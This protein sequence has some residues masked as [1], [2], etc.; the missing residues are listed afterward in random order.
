MPGPE[1]LLSEAA[2]PP[3]TTSVPLAISARLVHLL[4]S[5]SVQT[6]AD[7][8]SI[9]YNRLRFRALRGRSHKQKTDVPEMNLSRIGWIA[10]NVAAPAAAFAGP[11]E[12]LIEGM[13]KCAVVA[14]NTARLA[15]YD[16]LAPQL[17]AARAAPPATDNR[18]WY[19]PGRIFGTSPS[20]QTTP[21]QFGAENL[22]PPAPPPPRPGEPP[23][24]VPP[25]ALD[26]I[27]SKVKDLAPNPP[28]PFG[29]FLANVGAW[30]QLEGDTDRVH[31]RRGELNTVVI[32]RGALGSYNMRVNEAGVS[33]K[34]RRLK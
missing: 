2:A 29:D 8:C 3:I 26:G 7:G 31:F 20:A 10:V 6:L 19:D 22:A 5:M 12:E 24:P 11:Q 21:E 4:R 15:C 33:V 13:A 23:P 34:V 18:A 25:Q 1:P 16:A 9:P 32:S 17:K 30:Q 27:G 14:D 28:G